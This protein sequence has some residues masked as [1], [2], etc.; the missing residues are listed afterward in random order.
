[1]DRLKTMLME[2]NITFTDSTFN[3][4][5]GIGEQPF[6]SNIASITC[7]HTPTYPY[8]HPHTYMYLLLLRHIR[9][10]QYV[11]YTMSSMQLNRSAELLQFQLEEIWPIAFAV[12]HPIPILVL[13]CDLRDRE[14]KALE[15][16]IS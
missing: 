4:E 9:A 13:I 5:D 12:R 10:V 15:N 16:D 7:I 1:M 3:D 8:A 2:N 6:V 11:C 14:L